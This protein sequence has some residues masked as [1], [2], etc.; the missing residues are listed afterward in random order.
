MQSKALSLL[1]FLV[2]PLG[3]VSR[4][5]VFAGIFALALAGCSN[6]RLTADIKALEAQVNHS[7]DLLDAATSQLDSANAELDRLT[8]ERDSIIEKHEKSLADNLAAR[9]ALESKVE[10]LWAELVDANMQVQLLQREKRDQTDEL[11]P[12]GTW[13]ST[14][15]SLRLVLSQANVGL[16]DLP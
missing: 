14:T 5:T 10:E 3:F 16:R 11:S 7:A 15:K 8:R 2:S 12:T 9:S 4:L 1:A 13:V 6:E